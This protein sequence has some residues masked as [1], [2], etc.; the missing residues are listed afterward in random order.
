MSKDDI[1]LLPAPTSS[2]TSS[3]LEQEK[4][5]QAILSSIP[6]YFKPNGSNTLTN[7]SL[8]GLSPGTAEISG[9]SS[10]DLDLF[11]PL[12]VFFKALIS[13]WF[14]LGCT[15]CYLCFG[16]ISKGTGATI[17]WLCKESRTWRGHLPSI[18]LLALAALHS[19]IADGLDHTNPA[20]SA[21]LC[22]HHN[23]PFIPTCW[24]KGSLLSPVNGS[25]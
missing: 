1:L 23:V 2:E 17:V 5:L 4:Y 12:F 19:R 13:F 14:P 16:L 8:V 7:R 9:A 20:P 18:S 6:I 10:T 3:S 11:L 25:S 21:M 15:K 24:V 22:H